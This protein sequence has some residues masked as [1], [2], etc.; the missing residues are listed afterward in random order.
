M[1]TESMVIANRS[2]SIEAAMGHGLRLK[3]S[4]RPALPQDRY[5]GRK[6]AREL[7][8]LLRWGMKRGINGIDILHGERGGTADPGGRFLEKEALRHGLPFSAGGH[9]GAGFARWLPKDLFSTRPDL[10]RMDA[11]GKRTPS[12]NFCTAA[13]EALGRAIGEVANLLDR[14][15]RARLLQV[16]AE[17]VI[18]GSWCHCPACRRR[19]PA[20]QYAAVIA[21]A[22]G[23]L[24]ARKPGMQIGFLLYHDTL[25]G[26][27]RKSGGPG[28]PRAFP[29]NVYAL[30][31][32]RERCYAHAIDDPR[33]RRNRF[34]WNSLLRAKE[35]FGDRVDVFEYYGDNV[36][37]HYFNV[38]IPRVIA[39]DLRAYRRVGVR[40]IQCLTFGAYSLWAHGLNLAVF[41]WLASGM[42]TD[43]DA[44]IA[45]Y[46]RERFGA[47]AEGRMVEY[48]RRLERIQAGYLGFCGYAD[49]WI[50]DLRG[51]WGKSME[52]AA[53][54]RRVAT[55]RAQFPVLTDLL[56]LAAPR[57]RGKSFATNLRAEQSSLA[58]TRIELEQL[59]M[60]M[61]SGIRFTA[62][63]RNAWGEKEKASEADARQRQWEIAMTVPESIRGQV[64]GALA[65]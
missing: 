16:W 44:A 11:K 28:A 29:P 43:V 53:H 12:G 8:E 54:R 2:W 36:L 48:Y 50:C 21:T 58:I 38:A 33:C 35:L 63:A 7:V 31:A 15:P 62:G 42:E 65:P 24:A 52:Y 1:A 32:P 19:T 5:N 64:F 40:E 26:L 3:R 30:Y 9:V 49:D 13:P 22:A 51:C 37:W 6:Y 10:F 18:D 45:R 57:V 20:E 61:D 55:C 56:A 46:A 27:T 60:R 34:Y 25:G 4:A 39:A 41:A 14:H 59:D 47:R 23:V 17:D